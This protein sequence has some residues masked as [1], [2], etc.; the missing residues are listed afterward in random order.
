MSRRRK[1]KGRCIHTL[2]RHPQIPV[3]IKQSSV[4]TPWASAVPEEPEEA[5]AKRRG[6]SDRGDRR[7]QLGIGMIKGW[8]WRKD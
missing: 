6:G 7:V 5:E 8:G 2:V 4:L 3:G 1:D